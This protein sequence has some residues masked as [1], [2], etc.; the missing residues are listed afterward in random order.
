VGI[1]PLFLFLQIILISLVYSFLESVNISIFFPIL[2]SVLGGKNETTIPFFKYLEKTIRALPFGDPFI[3]ACILLVVVLVAKEL[4]GFFL[5]VFT[6]RGMGK[7]VGDAKESIFEKYSKLDY[8]FYL[9]NKQGDLIYKLTTAPAKLGN[10]LQFVPQIITAIFMT[11]AIGILLFSLSSTVTIFLL[12]VGFLFNF[13]TQLLAKKVSYH[14]GTE[15]AVVCSVAN[16]TANEFIDGFKHIKTVNGFK[17]WRDKFTKAIRRY[18][19]LVVKDTFW[20]SIPESIIQLVPAVILI[21]IA[22]FLKIK[23]TGKDLIMSNLA[24][25]SVYTYAFYRLVPFLTSFGKLRMQIMGALP[26]VELIYHLL[27][28]KTNNLAD[29]D[30][31]LKDIEKEIRFDNVFFSYKNKQAVLNGLNLLIE[32][33]KTTAIVGQSGAGKSTIIN[34]LIRLFSPEKGAIT[35]D[36][37]DINKI[38][39]SSLSS[40]IGLVSQDA[41]IFNA[42]IKTNIL[43]GR[44]D[45]PFENVLAASKIANAHEFI[46]QLPNG[47]DTIVGDKG[48]KLSGGQRQRIAIART[49]LQNA[50]ILI[51]DEATSALDYHSEILVQNAINKISVNK[52]IIIIAHRLSTI[53]N[54]DKIVLLHDGKII[55]EGTHQQLMKNS[56][57]YEGLYRTQEKYHK[58]SA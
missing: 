7:V 19:E 39:N 23:G 55:E 2:N 16:V 14:L 18:E 37:V 38:K 30:Y 52:T 45:M 36:G 20:V 44:E 15:R 58:V 10:C 8:L 41:F 21:F 12:V 31:A 1:V 51:L 47:Y 50:K 17:F 48:L 29:G 6:G 28:Q 40:M 22:V 27:H 43:F 5:K 34:L 9:E 33:G 56:G 46:L 35:F 25:M 42:S 57:L 32:K 54:A 4:V 24:V 11:I 53:I 49:I 3:N 13:L 26:D